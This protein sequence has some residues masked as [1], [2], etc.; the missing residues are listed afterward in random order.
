MSAPLPTR[1]WPTAWARLGTRLLSGLGLLATAAHAQ[2][3]PDTTAGAWP[4][5]LQQALRQ[6]GVPAEAVSLLVWPVDAPQPRWQ[7]Q[8]DAPRQ[9]ASV[10]K[11]F[12]TGVALRQLGPAHVW[13]T[14][15]GLGGPLLAN[16]VLDGPL[17][18]RGG[19]DPSLL[20]EHVQRMMARWRGAG[21]RDIR[22]GIVVDR[23]L[24]ELPAHDPNAFDGQSLRPYNAGPD[25]L[26]LNHQ[27]VTLRL[28]P[29]AARPGLARTESYR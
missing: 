28:M 8:A 23:S 24:F 19:G 13:R 21:L 11:L 6:S 20:I 10:M 1:S 12:T 9:A 4:A 2:S 14:E 26:L 18:L 3:A 29:D 17:Y 27:S 5:P 16:G 7:H 25:A 15:V 22:G